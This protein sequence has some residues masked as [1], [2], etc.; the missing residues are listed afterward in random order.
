MTTIVTIHRK[1]NLV[2]AAAWGFMLLSSILP[3]IILHEVLHRPDLVASVTW[4]RLLILA[5]L[6]AVSWLWQP[7]RPLWKYAAILLIFAGGQEVMNRVRET[8][9]WQNTL[10]QAGSSFARDYLSVQVWKLGVTG[11]VLLG[12]F[13]LGFRRKDAFLVRGQ[14]D[15]P[16][17]PVKWLG[18]PKPEPWTHFG[19][20]WIIF[21]SIGMVVLLNIFGTVHLDSLMSVWGMIPVILI[22]SA[23][24]A[25][26]EEVTYR[27]AQLAPLEPAVGSRQALWIVAVLFAIMHYYSAINGVAGVI[28]TIFMGWMLTKAMLET[29][30]F[31]WSWLI[32]FTQDVIIFWFIA[33]GASRLS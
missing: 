5:G 32:H 21:L 19:T 29:R 16:I 26:N 8:A 18:F 17:T 27:A 28:L 1:N 14:L 23:L 20:K 11:I 2:I 7:L 25:F 13:A 33:G 12:L 9:V 10:N 24:N 30:G 3:E 31:F 15:A 4:G 22:L 6:T